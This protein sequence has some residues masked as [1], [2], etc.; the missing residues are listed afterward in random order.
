[1]MKRRLHFIKMDELKSTCIG[2]SVQSSAFRVFL[3]SPPTFSVILVLNKQGL[4]SIV[5]GAPRICPT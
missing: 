1:M 3:D 5:V 2:F 4:D